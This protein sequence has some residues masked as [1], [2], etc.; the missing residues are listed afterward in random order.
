MLHQSSLKLSAVF[1]IG[2]HY[3]DLPLLS[4]IQSFFGG[5]G[6]VAVRGQSASYSVRKLEDIINIIIPHFVKYPLQRAK[7]MDFKLW[8]RCVKLMDRK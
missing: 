7:G 5:V 4:E 8:L 3:K 2:L 1:R 6:Q